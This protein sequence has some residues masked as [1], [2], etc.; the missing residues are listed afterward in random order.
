MLDPDLVTLRQQAERGDQDAVDQLSSRS[1]SMISWSGEV[2]PIRWP[3][4]C[5]CDG[6]FERPDGQEAVVGDPPARRTRAD[7]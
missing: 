5:R 2:R 6:D 7:H 1:H 4:I 3:C